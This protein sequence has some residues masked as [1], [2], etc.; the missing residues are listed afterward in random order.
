MPLPNHSAEFV[1]VD[2]GNRE[3]FATGSV[4]DSRTGKGR[5]DL[6]PPGPIKRLAKLYERGAVKYGDRNWLKGQPLS[7][8][9]DSMLRHAF[10]Y[11]AGERTEDHLAAVVFNAFALM[12]YEAML[13]DGRLPKEF[14]DL[15]VRNKEMK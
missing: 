6:I 10:A 15:P 14:D 4:R 1:T 5:Y 7:R 12:E 8:T 3:E 2:T 13:A 9:A 11:L